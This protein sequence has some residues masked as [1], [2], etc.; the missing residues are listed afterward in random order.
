MSVLR[1]NIQAGLRA[2]IYPRQ[3]LL[4]V[5]KELLP[6]VPGAPVG[7]L[8]IRP[9]ARLLHAQVRPRARWSER[10]FHHTPKIVGRIVVHKIPGVGQR[11]VRLDGQDLAVQHAAPVSAKVETVTDDWLEVVLHQPLLDQVWLGERAPDL[12]RRMRYLAFD[13][14]GARFDRRIAHWSIRSSKS[15]RSSNR[16]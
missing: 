8:L 11:L 1:S 2:S 6:P 12:F 4:Q 16:L 14:D 15:P 13:N 9:E 3:D 7:L 5:C 10:K